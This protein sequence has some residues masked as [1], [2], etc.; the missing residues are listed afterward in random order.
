M[1]VLFLQTSESTYRPLLDQTSRTVREYCSRHGCS[2]ELVFGILRGFHPWQA[3]FNRI[4]ML[5][6]L[7]D[8][9][10]SGW[11]CYM[12][13]DAYIADLDF[14]IRTYLIDKSGTSLIIGAG[15]PDAP[16]WHVN[17][18]VFLINLSHS[19]GKRIVR[20]WSDRFSAITDLQ[21]QSYDDWTTAPEDQLLLA[22]TLQAMPEIEDMVHIDKQVPHVINYSDGLFIKQQLRAYGSFD[23][24]VRRTE[25]EVNSVLD[26]VR[27]GSATR[28]RALAT[29]ARIQEEVARAVYTTILLR[30]PESTELRDAADQLRG[31]A[32]VA[33]LMESCFRCKEFAEKHHLFLQK[34]VSAGTSVVD[35]R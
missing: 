32:G 1:S 26:P 31:G 17:A 14:D 5:R 13:A 6:Q 35:P 24:R 19:A 34:Y 18:G 33:E 15:A 12:D 25:E 30:E 9:G 20:G 3:T 27:Q 28:S 29:L 8:V 7:L 10:H 23:E 21:L 11:V 16:W 4:S 22:Q 2:Y